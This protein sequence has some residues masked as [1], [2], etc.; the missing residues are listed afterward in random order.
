VGNLN[1]FFLLRRSRYRSHTREV[2]PIEILVESLFD[3]LSTLEFRSSLLN[4]T[5]A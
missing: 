2:D 1:A 4:D 3:F 5:I